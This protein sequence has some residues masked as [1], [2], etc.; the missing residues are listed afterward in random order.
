[1]LRICSLILILAAC[2]LVWGCAAGGTATEPKIPQNKTEN[3]ES[4]Q[5]SV[6][7]AAAQN[8]EKTTASASVPKIPKKQCL[9]NDAFLTESFVASS[10]A[11]A[12][13]NADRV[14]LAA[15]DSMGNAVAWILDPKGNFERKQIAENGQLACLEKYQDGFRTGVILRDA[16]HGTYTLEINAFDEHNAQIKSEDWAAVTRGFVPDP[17]THCVFLDR[18]DIIVTGTRPHGNKAPYHGMFRLQSRSLTLFEGTSEHVPDLIDGRIVNGT[19]QILVREVKRNAE[20]KPVWPHVVYEIGDDD[21]LQPLIEADFIV[22]GDDGWIS[23]TKNGCII[24]KDGHQS[25][26]NADIE[27]TEVQYLPGF[28]DGTCMMWHSKSSAWIA[29]IEQ[30]DPPKIFEIPNDIQLLPIRLSE[31]SG[32]LAMMLDQNKPDTAA[33][34]V[35]VTPDWDCLNSE[36]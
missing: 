13:I 30:N 32:W 36:K 20:N 35:I 33:G 25:C 15:N 6:K 5:N 34:F 29:R 8:A 7:P 21:K 28:C 14:V 24:Q 17:G 23:L 4:V 9:K 31:K 22:P 3:I 26:V 10:L 18:R 16:A 27:L 1:M 12:E 2:A 19:P 11:V